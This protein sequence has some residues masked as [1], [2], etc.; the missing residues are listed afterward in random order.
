MDASI[1]PG[2]IRI[3]RARLQQ[4]TIPGKVQEAYEAYQR[5]DFSR[6]ETLYRMALNR[7]PQNRDAL[8][9]IAAL[10]WRNGDRAGAA[11]I[12]SRLLQ[13]NPEDSAARSALVTL[14]KDPNAV[15]DE[16]S[17]KLML[18]RAPDS[19]HLRFVL[20]NVYA[21]QA[22]WS[23]A[24]QAYFDALR[25]D[26]ENPDY[27]FNLAV[28]LDHLGQQ[29]AA[30]GYYRKAV[31]FAGRRSSKFAAADAQSRIQALASASGSKP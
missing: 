28:S 16:S 14:R 15:A 27:A 18:T 11:G 6:A 24:Q 21:R 20:G 3:T 10:A 5:G 25:R 26:K 4:A 9:G 22:R 13:L 8:L 30:L 29:A 31:E 2:E 19:P 1:M 23:E 7:H 12:Y 17:I